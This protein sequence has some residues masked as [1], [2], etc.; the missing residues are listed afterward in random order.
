MVLRKRESRSPPPSASGL[1]RAP[2]A[3]FLCLPKK[4]IQAHTFTNT[5]PPAALSQTGVREKIRPVGLS[6]S[7]A[8]PRCGLFTINLLACSLQM[9]NLSECRDAPRCI[10]R[11]IKILTL[12]GSAFRD[13]AAWWYS[14]TPMRSRRTR[15]CQKFILTLPH[16]PE[17]GY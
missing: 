8:A 17:Y 12:V 2:E 4:Q 10:L 16:I 5:G 6:R 14:P 3:F 7:M 1:T 11:V 15:L 13:E 9:I